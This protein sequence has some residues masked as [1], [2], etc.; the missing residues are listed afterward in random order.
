MQYYI[1]LLP[2]PLNTTSNCAHIRAYHNIMYPHMATASAVIATQNRT[3][4]DVA[5]S[6]CTKRTYNVQCTRDILEY[7]HHH[8]KLQIIYC[9]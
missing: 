3:P 8:Q 2:L 5:Y 9:L 1:I 6:G 4:L 7:H